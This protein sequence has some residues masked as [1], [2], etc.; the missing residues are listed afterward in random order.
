MLESKAQVS[1]SLGEQLPFA[2][3]TVAC[4]SHYR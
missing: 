1:C 4:L 2:S 3:A